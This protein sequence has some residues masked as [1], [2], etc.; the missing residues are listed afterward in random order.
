MQELVGERV[1]LAVGQRYFERPGKD[2]YHKNTFCSLVPVM[3]SDWTLPDP[4]DYPNCGLVWWKLRRGAHSFAEP[5]RLL[6]GVLQEP[7]EF[8]E[9]DL[10]SMCYQVDIESIEPVRPRDFIE[11]VTISST[12]VKDL[13]E[14]VRR[15]GVLEIDHPPTATVLV[16]WRDRLFGPFVTSMH[17]RPED[18]G[19][20]YRVSL[21]PEFQDYTV[22]EIPEV[23]LE[24]HSDAVMSV[25]AELTFEDRNPREVDPNNIVECRYEV[26][27]GEVFEALSHGDFRTVELQTDEQIIRG[28]ARRL[29]SRKKKQ[30]LS[31][32]LTEMSA[33]ATEEPGASGHL[34][35]VLEVIGQLEVSESETRKLADGLIESGLLKSELD[36]AIAARTAD[37]ISEHSTEIQ[38]EI[39]EKIR[40]EQQNVE[41]L[42]EESRRLADDAET[43]KRR[44]HTKL[45]GELKQLREQAETEIRGERQRL[46][47]EQKELDRQQEIISG[48]LEAVTKSFTEGRDDLINQVLSLAPILRQTGVLDSRPREEASLP[49]T[50]AGS[51]AV[52]LRQESLE[53]PVFVVE[54]NQDPRDEGLSEEAFLD[55]FVMHAANRGLRFNRRDL[56]SFH[57]SVKCCDIT[58]LGGPSGTGKSTLPML[59]SEALQ[60]EDIPGRGR[61]LQV[62]VSP[63]WMDMRD[64]VGHV[65]ALTGEFL[66]AESGLY[67]HLIF[68][69]EEEGNK[70]RD[71]GIYVVNL[72][73]MNLAHVEHYFS[74]FLQALPRPHGDRCVACF[75]PHSVTKG[76]TY[77]R[78]PKLHLP[79]ALRFV[80]TVNFDETT[81]Q[82]S[83]RL[84]DRTNLISL[85]SEDLGSIPLTAIETGQV[86]VPGPSVSEGTYR[87]WV[88]EEPLKKPLAPFVDKIRPH[89]RVL[90]CPLTHRRY[91]AICRFVASSNGL[92]T[93]EE[94]FDL[95]ISQR[96]LPQIRGI[97]GA[98]AREAVEAIASAVET[99]GFERSRRH[100]EYIMQREADLE[101]FED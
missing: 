66:P 80:A 59:Y 70:G 62:G 93:E 52:D 49:A 18:S 55:R 1:F 40:E 27:K 36:E 61:Y 57:L 100:L 90:G 73:E 34:D 25:T 72:D 85:E 77:A 3:Q 53:M 51:P 16:R 69:K 63:A 60:G 15:P 11:I 42:R 82:L 81:K 19:G 94:A 56:L 26:L 28:L 41:R 38:A 99:A 45:Q 29:L 87:S 32:L 58:I 44:E 96:V 54:S 92:C 95:Q 35:T 97:Y 8:K 39:T 65:N 21:Q 7:W 71:S 13:R 24:A 68:A 9:D 91:R 5:G 14:V 30:S 88:G 33:R 76:S 50:A 46:K 98:A 101:G 22:L 79:R 31:A 84:L 2:S 12:V 10:N 6:T 17:E 75:D 43:T 74:G 4:E 47:E 83:L 23:E 20:K 89:L 48:H 78:W 86:A 37:Y 64:L 67:Q